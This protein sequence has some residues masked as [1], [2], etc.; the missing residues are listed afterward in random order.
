M[1]YNEHR[2]FFSG[3]EDGKVIGELIRKK[4][5]EK[6]ISLTELS[7]MAGISKSYLSYLERGMKTN[8]SI[9]ITKRVFKTLD[10]PI[11]ILNN[12][13]ESAPHQTQ[14]LTKR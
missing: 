14:L 4:R 5:M 9:Q 6:G 3:K 11:T 12:V 1:R 13:E 7:Q 2:L 10:L 8:P